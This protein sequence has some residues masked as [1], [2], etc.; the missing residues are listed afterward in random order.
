MYS[1]KDDLEQFC[2]NGVT[3]TYNSANPHASGITYGGY[4]K[5]IVVDQDFALRISDKLDLAASAPLLCSGLI[6]YSPLRLRKIAKGHKVGVVGLGGL[7]HMA[8]KFGH[9]FGTHIALLT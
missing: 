4:S 5:S 6:A 9:A 8:V 2:E 1:C 7:G 3:L